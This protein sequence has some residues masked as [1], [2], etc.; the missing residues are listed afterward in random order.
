[1]TTYRMVKESIIRRMRV[2]AIMKLIE[3]FGEFARLLQGTND[4]K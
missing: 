1:M 4:T 3:D 2:C